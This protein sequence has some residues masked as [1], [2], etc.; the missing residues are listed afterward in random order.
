MNASLGNICPPE[1][2]RQQ[3][4]LAFVSFVQSAVN[5]GVQDG[6]GGAAQRIQNLTTLKLLEPHCLERLDTVLVE[7]FGVPGDEDESEEDY[8]QDEDK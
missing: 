5:V 3:V 1:E 8:E 6:P 4:Q 2:A 7:E